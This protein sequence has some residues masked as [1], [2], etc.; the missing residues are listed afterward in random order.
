MRRYGIPPGDNALDRFLTGQG[1]MGF[2]GLGGEV[3]DTVV[4]PKLWEAKVVPQKGEMSEKG[5]WQNL[6][7]VAASL[8][9]ALYNTTG[10][11]S[12]RKDDE[13]DKEKNK[14][15]EAAAALDGDA[16]ISGSVNVSVLIA[17][18][19]PPKDGEELPELM[20]GTAAVPIYT[21]TSRTPAATGASSAAGT[22]YFHPS[23]ANTAPATSHPTRAQ[24]LS[25][26]KAAQ[27]AKEGRKERAAA[28]A[29]QQGEK[30]AA[31]ETQQQIDAAAAADAGAAA[32]APASRDRPVAVGSED[33]D[34]VRAASPT[35]TADTVT[36]AEEEVP[37]TATSTAAAGGSS[38]PT[39]APAPALVLPS[40]DTSTS[41]NLRNP[42]AA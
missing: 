10:A 40:A 14:D 29:Q 2:R 38:V 31:E 11:A 16:R 28:V 35:M 3:E 39:P 22:S 15:K 17:M 19:S 41:R 7:P 9:T 8:P 18:P 6:M 12:L 27:D 37:Q 32:A 4:P 26:Y 34:V 1:T 36:T 13:K 30:R 21:R 5:G 33:A 23:H 20:L 24:L 25:L 42:L